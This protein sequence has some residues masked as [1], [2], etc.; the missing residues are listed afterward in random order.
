MEKPGMNRLS[1][2]MKVLI[3]TFLVVFVFL[4]GVL[5]MERWREASQPPLV[6]TIYADDVALVAKQL[7]AGADVHTDF[8]DPSWEDVPRCAL[9]IACEQGNIQIVR[10][11]LDKGAQTDINTFDGWMN[12][13]LSVAI[14][15]RH[16]AV[17]KLLL[18]RGADP[19][20]TDGEMSMVELAKKTGDVRIIQMLKQAGAKE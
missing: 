7:A 1:I 9:L 20:V 13:P 2:P 4:F 10:L 17:V 8:R 5:L 19:N 6:Q 11:L 3:G 15:G 18:Q 12:S 16:T 14:E